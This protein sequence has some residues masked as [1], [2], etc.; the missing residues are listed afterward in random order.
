[1]EPEARGRRMFE[2]IRRA[3]QLRGQREPTVTLIEDLHWFD[4]GSDAYLAPLVEARAG[5]RALLVLNFRP[6]YRADWMQ[7]SYYQQLPLRPLGA[8]ATDELLRE[9]LGT[10][11]SLAG[12]PAQIRTRTGGNPFFIEEVVRALDETGGL[13]GQR[14]AYRLGRPVETI[15]V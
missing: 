11:P 8:E 1:M 9:L 14:G 10:D 2:L 5:T 6:E 12:L 4:S 15:A 3:I 7:Q 13:V